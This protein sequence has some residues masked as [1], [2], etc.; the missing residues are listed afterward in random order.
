MTR[1]DGN[2]TKKDLATMESFVLVHYKCSTSSEKLFL[3][4][5]FWREET[6]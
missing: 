3:I 5:G 6:K 1:E 2:R 4:D